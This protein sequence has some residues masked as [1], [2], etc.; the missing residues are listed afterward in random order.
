VLVWHAPT[1]T[2]NPSVP[3]RVVDEAMA[4]D[5][6]SAS[7]EYGAQFRSDIESYINR[8]AVEA[9]V[10]A[11]VFERPW[12]SGT[13]YSAF[14]DPSGG[15]ADSMTLAIAHRT[16][17]GVAV[18]DALREIK[19]PFSPSSAVGE[20]TD[21]LKGYHITKIQGDRYAGEW[22]REQFKKLGITYEPAQKPKS[23]LYQSLLPLINSNK[24]SLLDH[25]K[26]V[27]QICSLE[28]RT[29]RGG[30]DSIDHPLGAHDDLSNALAGVCAMLAKPGF[31]T[32]YSWLGDETFDLRAVERARFMA[33]VASGGRF[34]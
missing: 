18:L 14:C 5:P 29:A 34:A 9:C 7:A 30:R 17:D 23:D 25:R 19:P 26:M 24:V 4:A 20:F 16:R 31:D 33:Y 8:E 11:G 3:Q 13:V 28:R 22:P 10:D 2:M 27:Q 6:A 21:M 12:M 15:S 1:R 32:S